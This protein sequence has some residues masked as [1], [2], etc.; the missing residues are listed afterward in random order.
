MTATTMIAITM[1]GTMGTSLPDAEATALPLDALAAEEEALDAEALADEAC[2][3]AADS[4]DGACALEALKLI[5][6]K[7]TILPLKTHLAHQISL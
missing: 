1:M 3:L 4:D 7:P 2:A 6:C 5:Y